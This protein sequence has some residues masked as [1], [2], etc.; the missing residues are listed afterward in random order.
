MYK[1]ER[2]FPADT[3]APHHARMFVQKELA[4]MGCADPAELVVSELTSN[5][6]RHVPSATRLTVAITQVKNHVRLAVSTPDTAEPSEVRE[7][8]AWPTADVLN[9]RGLRIV[10]AVSQRWGVETG[11]HPTVWCELHC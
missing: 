3:E 7:T 4:G 8:A 9:G 1:A 11:S 10:D 6:I 2:S 5:I